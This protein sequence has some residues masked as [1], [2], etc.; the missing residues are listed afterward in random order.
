MQKAPRELPRRVDIASR[1]RFFSIAKDLFV[2]RYLSLQM[3]DCQPQ[4]PLR[5]GYWCT[6]FLGGK[7]VNTPVATRRRDSVENHPKKRIACS[8]GTTSCL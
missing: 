7:H 3:L 6:P 1:C 5:V 8:C 4:A 2:R